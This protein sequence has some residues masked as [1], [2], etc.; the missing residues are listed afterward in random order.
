MQCGSL[1]AFSIAFKPRDLTSKIEEATRNF[2]IVSSGPHL[3]EQSHPYFRAT[4]KPSE[5]LH[6]SMELRDKMESG[7]DKFDY[8]RSAAMDTAQTCCGHE[9]FEN[10]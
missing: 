6:D 1:R 10:V 3:V 5:N 4:K 8:E 2:S 9:Q 7:G